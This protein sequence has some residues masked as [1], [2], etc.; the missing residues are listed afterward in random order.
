[1]RKGQ[2]EF[3]TLLK[4]LLMLLV[5]GVMITIIL[6]RIVHADLSFPGWDLLFH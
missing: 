6:L 5:V 3:G 1:M 2:I 4:W